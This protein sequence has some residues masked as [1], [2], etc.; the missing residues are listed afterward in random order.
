MPGPRLSTDLRER[1]VS[2]WKKSET[3]KAR[4]QIKN[5]KSY[6][7]IGEQLQVNPDTVRKIIKKFKDT[8][9][10]E[11]LEVSGR[12]R[13][14]SP[15]DDRNIAR[16]AN[17]NSKITRKYVSKINFNFSVINN[18]FIIGLFKTNYRIWELK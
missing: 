4:G 13:K 18:I 6:P 5:V 10:I 2:V 15:Q 7:Q 17:S 3:A 1:I 14:T 11:D 8:G 16:L 9:T 12:P